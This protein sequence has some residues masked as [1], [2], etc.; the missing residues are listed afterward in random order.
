MLCIDYQLYMSSQ[1]Y[2]KPQHGKSKS[3]KAKVTQSR[4]VINNKEDIIKSTPSKSLDNKV[5]NEQHNEQYSEQNNEQLCSTQS[6][7]KDSRFRN[8]TNNNE[9]NDNKETSFILKKAKTTGNYSI[10]RKA[11]INGLDT[12]QRVKYTMYNAYLPFGKE[13]YNDN[14][15]LNAIIND[16]NNLNY[17]MLFTLNRIAR[18]FDE[19]N[20]IDTCKHKYNIDN[21]QFFPFIKALPSDENNNTV[22][23]YS[24]R[25]YFKYGAKITHAKFVGELSADQLK[26]KTCNI[27]IDLGSMWVNDSSMM[28]G[29]NIFISHITVLN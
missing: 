29:I 13:D 24:I 19:L 10:L 8:K 14:V 15:I 17:N 25:L 12:L 7:N 9:T 6:T 16:S 28:Y 2:S 20:T 5:N 27:N 11:R 18:T 22:K 21:K 26:G 4:V 1:S 23:Q 3:V